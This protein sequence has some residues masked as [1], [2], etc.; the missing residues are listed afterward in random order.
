MEGFILAHSSSA[1]SI[2]VGT[3]R[4]QESKAAKSLGV[5]S[6]EGK[7]DEHIMRSAT[8]LDFVQPRTSAPVMAV[9]TLKV[10]VST[11]T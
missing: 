8:C 10:C 6:Q 9:A 1:Q 5:H 2:L 4:R 7:G 11:S 3:S